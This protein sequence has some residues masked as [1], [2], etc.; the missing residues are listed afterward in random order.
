MSGNILLYERYLVLL[1]TSIDQFE[2]HA[3]ECFGVFVA[4][5]LLCGADDFVRAFM[6]EAHK[7]RMTDGDYVYIA[8]GILP[9]DSLLRPWQRNDSL[10]GDAS[11][12]YFPM[13]QVYR[14]TASS[15]QRAFRE[16]ILR[17]FDMI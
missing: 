13:L 15:P 7:R 5:L 3:N 2:L 10:D 4:V 6:L 17:V 16:C 9:R 1:V 12:A 11:A 14:T 8:T